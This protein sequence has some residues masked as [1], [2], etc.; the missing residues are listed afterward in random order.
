M[1]DLLLLRRAAIIGVLG[2]GE[3]VMNVAAIE[4][5]RPVYLLLTRCL[6]W[7][8]MQSI[9]VLP[10]M[11]DR[12]QGVDL[13]AITRNRGPNCQALYF[14]DQGVEVGEDL[15]GR[16]VQDDLSGGRD[17]RNP[18]MKYAA[19]AKWRGGGCRA[20][21]KESQLLRQFRH[22]VCIGEVSALRFPLPEVRTEKGMGRTERRGKG[23]LSFD[24][25][26]CD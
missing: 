1:S 17:P 6:L 26:E 20:G 14:V 9:N 2:V 5:L 24:E 19:G 22:V 12:V 21:D 7:H 10:L 13:A 8:L 11:C 15:N 18:V 25:R 4:R 16:A 23:S 3:V